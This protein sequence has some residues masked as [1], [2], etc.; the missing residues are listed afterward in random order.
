MYDDEWCDNSSS[1]KAKVKAQNMKNEVFIPPF[2]CT[3]SVQFD[4]HRFRLVK[5]FVVSFPLTWNTW[6][7]INFGTICLSFLTDL[8]PFSSLQQFHKW[9]KLSNWKLNKNQITMIHSTWLD[10]RNKER[11]K[12]KKKNNNENYKLKIKKKS[13]WYSFEM[14]KHNQNKGHKQSVVQTRC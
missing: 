8:I 7:S 5:N 12:K 2:V 10:G 14:C 1:A 13:I 6:L 11:M 9:Y 3:R 4:S